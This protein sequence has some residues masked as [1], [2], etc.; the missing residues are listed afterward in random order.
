MPATNPKLADEL[1]ALAEKATAGPWKA[2]PYRGH[3]GSQV[4]AGEPGPET[5]KLILAEG[6]ADDADAALIVALRNNLPEILAALT[7]RSD[8]WRDIEGAPRD[9]LALIGGW[10]PEGEEYAAG[11]WWQNIGHCTKHGVYG[12]W[13]DCA[14]PTHWQPLP[15]PPESTP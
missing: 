3:I 12:D 4:W 5:A 8:G 6:D 13:A 15:T 2:N 9:G 14:E 1:I 7:A 10:W 11:T